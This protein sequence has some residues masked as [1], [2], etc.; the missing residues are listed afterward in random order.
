MEIRAIKIGG[1]V[2]TEKSRPYT[3]NILEID[4][5]TAEIWESILTDKKSK[6]VIVHGGGSFAHP[7]A[8]VFKRKFS[9]TARSELAYPLTT[10]AIRRLNYLFTKSLIDYGI[11]AIS[12]SPSISI[13]YSKN[14]PVFFN[15]D[16]IN[17]LLKSGF[18]PVLHGDV[19]LDFDNNKLV[20]LSG[21]S[22]IKILSEL[23]PLKDIVIFTN[24][25][26]VLKDVHDQNSVIRCITP[27]MKLQNIFKSQ[28]D[29]IDVTGG[30][31]HKVR[32]LLD[33]YKSKGVPSL[34]TSAKP[35]GNIKKALLNPFSVMGT[36][37]GRCPEDG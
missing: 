8:S 20:A 15:I 22:I 28:P 32:A 4:R 24:V 12:I 30:M 29:R 9:D 1:S 27:E 6:F 33:I 7:I 34:I 19:I 25:P 36:W 18:V 10:L 31:E 13:A 14:Q 16:L 23:L 11:K 2:I 3:P 37:I 5:V 35:S 26:G 17:Q 21:E